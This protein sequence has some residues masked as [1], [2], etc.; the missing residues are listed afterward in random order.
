MLIYME[1]FDHITASVVDPP[2]DTDYGLDAGRYGLDP[3]RP[4]VNDSRYGVGN[5]MYI[6]ARNDRSPFELLVDSRV[7]SY[8]IIVG[9]ALKII[10]IPFSFLGFQ[11]DI[12]DENSRTLLRAQ[13]SDVSGDLS[14]N[15]VI[16]VIT[17]DYATTIASNQPIP[18]IYGEWF[19][20]EC[21]VLSDPTAAGRVEM[22]LNGASIIDYTGATS[23]EGIAKITRV[24]LNNRYSNTPVDYTAHVDDFYCIAN[25]LPGLQGFQGDVQIL[26]VPILTESTPQDLTLVGAS[27]HAGALN[28]PKNIVTTTAEYLHPTDAVDPKEYDKYTMQDIVLGAGAVITA[29]GASAIIRGTPASNF[30]LDLALQDPLA[31]ETIAEVGYQILFDDYETVF[32]SFD[33]SPA[34]VPWTKDALND[35]TFSVGL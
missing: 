10:N 15:P 17:N 23:F 14:S 34:N 19:H 11:I 4:I 31:N 33:E 28:R 13:I 8:D 16:D 18:I 29:V 27:T 30:V 21:R 22:L 32:Y 26:H 7:T 1:G 24:H 5:S 35:C 6:N 25:D 2:V 12:Q 20:L 9:V 3:P